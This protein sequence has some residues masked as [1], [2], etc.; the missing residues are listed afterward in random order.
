MCHDEEDH[1]GI[2]CVFCALIDLALEYWTST[3]SEDRQEKLRIFQ[4][5]MVLHKIR[6]PVDD[7]IHRYA[8]LAPFV[9]QDAHE[10]F[11]GL[12]NMLKYVNNDWIDNVENRAIDRLFE[13]KLKRHWT[14]ED[15]G[16][17]R[18]YLERVNGLQVRMPDTPVRN[19]NLDHYV[20]G[21]FA[22]EHMTVRCNSMACN[23]R[24]RERVRKTHISAAPE[25]LVVQMGRFRINNYGDTEKVYD[26]IEYGEMLDLSRYTSQVPGM[27]PGVTHDKRALRYRL[28]GIVSHQGRGGSKSGGHYIATVRCRNGVD[29]ACAND[30]TVDDLPAKKDRLLK[31]AESRAFQSYLPV[32]QKVGGKMMKRI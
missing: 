5:A 20:E 4:R 2:T 18:R 1:D 28:H 9:Q 16:A 14:C 27:V 25:I 3:E 26:N 29:F 13:V 12:T 6:C 32:Y 22:D 8:V 24:D 19:R 15:C 31:Q 30:N 10:F 7:A 11:A 23:G 21:Y 17:V